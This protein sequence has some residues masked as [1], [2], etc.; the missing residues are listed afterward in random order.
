MWLN[1]SSFELDTSYK[2]EKSTTF[3]FSITS[4]H[5]IIILVPSLYQNNS[6]EI[7]WYQSVQICINSVRSIWRLRLGLKIESTTIGISYTSNRMRLLLCAYVCVCISFCVCVKWCMK[8]MQGSCSWNP[9]GTH[10]LHLCVR[11]LI[12]LQIKAKNEPRE[13]C[14]MR[15][16]VFLM[17]MLG[18]FSWEES[19]NKN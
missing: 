1:H 11:L 4:L 17:C 16:A 14:L 2:I 8:E 15:W 13:L 6:H 10:L 3:I 12:Y 18:D 19:E 9:P 5:P 7:I